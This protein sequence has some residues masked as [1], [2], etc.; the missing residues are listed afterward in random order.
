MKIIIT[1]KIPIEHT[2]EYSAYFILYTVGGIPFY[3]YCC[4][5][6][7]IDNDRFII[8]MCVKW[9]KNHIKNILGYHSEG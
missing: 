2:N 5:S 6:H 8:E 7:E 4:L 9:Y 1:K 3:Q